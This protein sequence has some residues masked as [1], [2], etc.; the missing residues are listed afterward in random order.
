[1]PDEIRKET[2]GSGSQVQGDRLVEAIVA[3]KAQEEPPSPYFE[4]GMDRFVDDLIARVEKLEG[5]LD[6]KQ[7]EVDCAEQGVEVLQAR[8]EE[9]EAALAG[10]A[11]NVIYFAEQ[12]ALDRADEALRKALPWGEYQQAVD[13]LL[14]LKEKPDAE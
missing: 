3:W 13:V 5:Q 6:D 11:G 7:V 8:V 14:A 2:T 4:S 12:Q 10:D 9:L 1:M